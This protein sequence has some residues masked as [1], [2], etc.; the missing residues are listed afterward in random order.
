MEWDRFNHK[1][2]FE[3]L[4]NV[5]DEARARDR[6]RQPQQPP[7]YHSER[8]TATRQPEKLLNHYQQRFSPKNTHTPSGFV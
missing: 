6:L 7:S 5:P 8:F 4:K 3:L 2:A 1:Q